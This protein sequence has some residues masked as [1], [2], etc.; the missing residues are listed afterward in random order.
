MPVTVPHS[1][2]T[3]R[4]RKEGGPLVAE[5]STLAAAGYCDRNIAP[6]YMYIKG[7]RETVLYERSPHNDVHDASGEDL[8]A[9][10][11]KPV[12]PLCRQELPELHLLN[13]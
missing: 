11:Y 9:M 10:V 12:P 8:V 1:Q 7:E 13:D 5:H 4:G 6:S 3:F 2:F